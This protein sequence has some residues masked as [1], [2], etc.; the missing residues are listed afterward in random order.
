MRIDSR[1]KR[2]RFASKSKPSGFIKGAVPVIRQ[3]FD[4]R[5]DQ[6]R[7]VGA[8][9]T[10]GMVA[11]VD[12]LASETQVCG[13][14]WGPEWYRTEVLLVVGDY[15][16]TTPPSYINQIDCT[17]IHLILLATTS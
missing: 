12:H 13:G 10:D 14:R 11:I 16:V 7:K 15:K 9:A 8:M 3:V 4:R 1:T 17:K 5:K 2:A 6:G